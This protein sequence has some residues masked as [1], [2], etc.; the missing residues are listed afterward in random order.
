MMLNKYA[1]ALLAL[2][3]CFAFDC[4]AY[5]HSE[6]YRR[7]I[8]VPNLSESMEYNCIKEE[9]MALLRKADT[10]KQQIQNTGLFSELVAKGLT[11]DKQMA[12]WQTYITSFCE[13][14]KESA[15]AY[16][17]SPQ[18]L[19]EECLYNFMATLVED[20]ENLLKSAQKR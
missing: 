1:T 14:S 7:C 10:L 5:D 13:Y 16:D 12:D 18:I 8:S 3:A 20:W 6:E 17:K 11:L 4:K 9:N 19:K 15:C 2:S